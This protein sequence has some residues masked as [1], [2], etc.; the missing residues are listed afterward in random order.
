VKTHSLK[1]R[2]LNDPHYWPIPRAQ[3]RGFDVYTP[4]GF[5]LHSAE[6]YP[7]LVLF[8][9]NA[10]K[11][12]SSMPLAVILDNLIAEKKIAPIVAAF[13]YQTENRDKEL[14]CSPAICNFVAAE[15]VPWMRQNYPITKDPAHTI[16]GGMSYG[17]LM[18]GY[19][20]HMHPEIFGNVLSMSGSYAWFA[21]IDQPGYRDPT[22]EGWL[23]AEF[24]KIPR[25]E[26]RFYLAAGKFENFTT[27]SLLGEN[28]R[29]RDI[30]LCKGYDVHYREF[31]GGHDSTGFRGAFVD[32]IIALMTPSPAP[33]PKTHTHPPPD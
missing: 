23:P 28:R 5:D 13:V 3:T 9:G 11:D 10:Y 16:I 27:Y 29:F 21:E 31:T 14:T 25:Q 19:C 30:L 17:G 8:D 18:S 32:G 15:L 4:P 6:P 7:L 26:I 1:S 20:A 22:A 33:A 2:H 24:V 12:D